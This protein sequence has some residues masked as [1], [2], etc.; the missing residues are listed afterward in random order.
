MNAHSVAR[1]LFAV[2]A[3]PYLAGRPLLR[4]LMLLWL[5]QTLALVVASLWRLEAYV[6]VYGLTRLRVA[7]YIWMGL[8]A[9]GLGIVFGQIRRD[10]PAAWMLLRSGALGA[11]VI[12][13]MAFINIDGLIATYNL[14]RAVAED[15]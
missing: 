7:A 12:Y 2:L 14:T 8:V 10:K 13:G 6:D 11:V 4:W 5:C 3:R 1:S 9:A 15:R